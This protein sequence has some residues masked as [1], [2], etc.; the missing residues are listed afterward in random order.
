MSAPTSAPATLKQTYLYAKHVAHNAKMVDFGGFNMPIH[1]GSQ[2]QEHLAVRENVGVFDV[3]HMRVC[4]ILGDT[5]AA[6]T[7]LR[8]LLSNDVQK[9]KPQQAL[10]SC[11]LNHNGGVVDDLIIYKIAEDNA[12]IENNKNI[13]NIAYRFILNAGCADKDIAWIHQELKNFHDL[14]LNSNLNLNLEI[15]PRKLNILAVQGPK[16]VDVLANI[17]NHASAEIQA[18]KTFFST[19]LQNAMSHDVFIARTGYTGED[20]F[21]I[22]LNDADVELFWKKLIQAGVQPCGL[23]ARDTL[24]LEAGMHLYGQDMDETILPTN[25]SLDWVVDTNDQQRD[26]VGKKTLET[27]AANQQLLGLYL[28]SGGILRAGQI[29]ETPHGAGLISSGTFSPSL[30]CS[31]ALARLP[32]NIKAGDE[33]LVNIRQQSLVAKV[34]KL[35]FVRRGIKKVEIV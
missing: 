27:T 33:V 20:G 15:A 28:K 30:S 4:D 19:N 29:I 7:F 21:E 34:V 18:L 26:F 6:E 3:S 11:M 5:A 8:H 17:F 9:L 1:Y 22:I 25:V 14:N 2:I 12:N 32:K 13:E 31:I 35:P 24:R 23:G 16:A 10:Y